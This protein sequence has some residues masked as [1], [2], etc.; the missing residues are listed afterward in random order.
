MDLWFR[1]TDHAVGQGL[2]CSGELSDDDGNSLL[3]YVYDCGSS[4]SNNVD[5]LKR[6]VR[7]SIGFRERVDVLY[8]SH[9]DEDHVNG[10]KFLARER[11]IGTIVVPATSLAERVLRFGGTHGANASS[12]SDIDA[13]II[14]DPQAG[15]TEV[16]PDSDILV[17]GET[18]PLSRGNDQAEIG[19]GEVE[20]SP[21]DSNGAIH[22]RTPKSSVW[23][24]KPWTVPEV[25]SSKALFLRELKFKDE[26]ALE[27][28][29][30][31]LLQSDAG[32]DAVRKAYESALKKVRKSDVMNFTSLCLYSGPAVL[33]KATH[34]ARRVPTGVFTS[35]GWQVREERAERSDV[36]AWG[37]RPGWIGTGDAL[38]K[39]KKRSS[40]FELEY[41][42]VADLVG[43]ITLPHHGSKRNFSRTIMFN[44][45]KSMVAVAS[46]GTKNTYGHP[47][48][49]VLAAVSSSGG[50]LVSVNESEDSRFTQVRHVKF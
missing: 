30:R 44:S 43:S 13:E 41:S 15:L 34:R 31:R 18:S 32:R 28:G 6:E 37:V 24:L 50:H 29:V 35:S 47:S 8:L 21:V 26:V 40:R 4:E 10:V 38:L 23:M 3:T 17:V 1:T 2:M 45:P 16:S 33:P 49:E 12:V 11:K 36:G 39:E 5:L 14:R 25:A 7:A 19:E 20:V 42:Q 27:K 22:V 46:S 48:P 9:F